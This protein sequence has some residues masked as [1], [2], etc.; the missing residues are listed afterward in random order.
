VYEG[1]NG[2]IAHAELTLS[3]GLIMLG[4]GNGDEYRRGFKSP[5][6]LGGI[7]TRS[8]YVV[9]ADMMRLMRRPWQRERW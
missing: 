2:M 3:G 8:C 7:E 9:V 5:E 1:E 4:F 6:E